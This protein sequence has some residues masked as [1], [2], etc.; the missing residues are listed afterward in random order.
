MWSHIDEHLVRANG[1]SVSCPRSE[2]RD[3][4]VVLDDAVHFK[5]HAARVYNVHLRPQIVLKTRRKGEFSDPVKSF[6]GKVIKKLASTSQSC[7]LL[8]PVIRLGTPM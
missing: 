3:S 5:N 7:N 2:C 6:S 4:G 1:G 8:R